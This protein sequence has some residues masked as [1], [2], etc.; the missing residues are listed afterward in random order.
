VAI[1]KIA[2]IGHQPMS[3]LIQY[4]HKLNHPRTAGAEQVRFAVAMLWP[5]DGTKKEAAK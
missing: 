3:F 4:Y 5:A 2:R 1:S